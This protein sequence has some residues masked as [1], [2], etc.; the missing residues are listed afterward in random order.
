VKKI[1]LPCLELLAALVGARIIAVLLPRDRPG[2]Q[3]C[4]VSL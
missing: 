4:N 2:L 1:T 3:G